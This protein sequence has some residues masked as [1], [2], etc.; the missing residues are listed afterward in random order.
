MDVG[1]LARQQTEFVLDLYRKIA[2]RA[3][4][5]NTVLSPISISLALSMVA[6]GAKGLTLEQIANS[7]KLPHGHLMHKFSTHLANILQSDGEQGLEL[8]CA[9]RIWVDQT[10]QLKPT[11]QKLLKDSYGAE[12]A[13]VDFRHKSTEARETINKWAENETHGKIANVLPP[14]A[15]SAHTKAILANAI[16]FNGSWENRFASSMTKDDDFHLA[17]GTTIQVPMMRSHKNQF[18]KSFP[19]HKVVRL[20]Y[21][22]KETTQRSFAMFI[23]LP[24]EN[25]TLLDLESSL[26]PQSLSS[27]LTNFGNK[28]PL[29]RF[30]LPK[31]KVTYGLEV[32]EPLKAMGM[33]L[34]FTPEGDFSDMTS[35]DGPLSISSVRHKAFVDVNEVGTE[36]AAVTTVEIS[37]MCMPMYTREPDTFVAD[38]PFMFLIMEEVSNAIV[39]SGRVTNPSKQA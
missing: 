5:E 6:A 13:S 39:F 1:A 28:V 32:S 10:I 25:I 22:L 34:P 23:L 11:F 18:F 4:E 17:D 33:E 21:A 16:Y 3:P 26:T 15:V 14:D 2:N 38:R 30:L 19:T 36:A 35:D 31:F 7:I 8:S 37:L 24:H 20:P 12:A 29:K 9:N 27:D